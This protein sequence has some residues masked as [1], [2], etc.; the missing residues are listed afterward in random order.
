MPRRPPEAPLPQLSLS[1]QFPG[2]K[3]DAPT[4]PK[5]RRWVR[6]VCDRPA[7]ITVRLVD[8]E[9]GQRLNRD[10]RGKDYPTNVL[11]FGYSIEPLLAGDIVLCLPVVLREAAE[12]RKSPE[13]HFA[14]LV[15]HG[16]LHLKGFDHETSP[17]EAARM[18][19][20]ERDILRSLGF[21]DPY[22]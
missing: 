2:G 8:A 3:T 16:M 15:V 4:R 7:E 19:A 6:A 17:R 9:E 13:A 18:E 1:I 14:H 22:L 11:S 21:S 5:I 12:Q 10:F 20:R